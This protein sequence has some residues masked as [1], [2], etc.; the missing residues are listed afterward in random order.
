VTSGAPDDDGAPPPE[1]PQRI[2]GVSTRLVVSGS[3]DF[4]ANNL[5]FMQNLA[6]WLVADEALLGIR[7]KSSGLPA[8]RPT[9][10]PEQ[11]AWK[12]VLLSWAPALL[13]AVGAVRQRRRRKPAGRAT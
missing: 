7:G 1:A 10:K 6:D 8:L 4:V 13:L 5:D 11:A 3:A 9:T 2:E 12:A